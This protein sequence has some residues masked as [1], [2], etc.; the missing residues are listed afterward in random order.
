MSPVARGVSLLAVMAL[1]LAPRSW[2]GEKKDDL[3]KPGPEHKIL[4]LL[5]GSFETRAKAYFDPSK[6][7]EEAAGKT[8]RK[9]IMQ[10]RFL[11]ELYEGKVMGQPFFGMG[12]YGFDRTQKKYTSVW[13]DNMGTGTTFGLG[14]YDPDKKTFTY[15]SEEID[16]YT[17]KKVKMR[18]TLKIVSD[19]EQLTEVF[20]RPAEGE[21][22]ERK[23]LE[24]RYT[25]KK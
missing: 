1:L 11:Q 15:L 22:A 23:V 21:G 16:P 3:T 13:V 9:F 5:E 24:V 2:G 14:T 12:I 19:N 10:G 4:A 7:P 8:Q 17:G 20:S 6:G 18:D 25:R